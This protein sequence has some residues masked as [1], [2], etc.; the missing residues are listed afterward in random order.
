MTFLEICKR[1]R[2]ECG[3]SGDGPASVSGQV[4]IYKKIVDWVTAAH[5]EIQLKHNNWRFD[6]GTVTATLSDGVETYQPNDVWSL[7]A[8]NW[9][10]DSMYVYRTAEGPTS[11]TWLSRLDYNQ[12]RQVRVPSVTGRPTYVSWAPNKA[13]SFYPLP[14]S[15][16]TLVADYWM[17]PMVMSANTDVPR[18]PSE[19]HMAIVW[20]AVMFWAASEENPALFQSARDNY[21]SVMNKLE[22]LELEGPFHAEPLA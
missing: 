19:H 14:S 20:R 10:F 12:Y 7:N 15:G 13:L 4:G 8:R 2:Q 6:W 18:I 11:R 1:V 21:Q 9:D 3:V 22:Q 5:E 17:E 16:L